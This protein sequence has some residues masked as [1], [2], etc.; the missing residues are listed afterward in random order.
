MKSFIETAA[1]GQIQKAWSSGSVDGVTTNPSHAPKTG[2]TAVAV[3][4]VE[5]ALR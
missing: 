1:F 3:H 5:V 2:R 4:R